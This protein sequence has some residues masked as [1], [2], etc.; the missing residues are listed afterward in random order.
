MGVPAGSECHAPLAP[1]TGLVEVGN[2]LLAGAVV[3]I[4]LDLLPDA[5]QCEHVRVKHPAKRT[6]TQLH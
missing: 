2:V 6:H 4:L 5:W 1:G 3:D